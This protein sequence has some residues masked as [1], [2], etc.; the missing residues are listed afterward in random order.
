[1]KTQY[2]KSSIKIRGKVSRGTRCMAAFLIFS[3]T[4]FQQFL[5]AQSVAPIPNIGKSAVI[6]D[7]QRAEINIRSIVPLA[8][9]SQERIP[10]HSSSHSGFASVTTKTDPPIPLK[11]PETVNRLEE[12][13]TEG[14]TGVRT[15]IPSTHYAVT[16]KVQSHLQKIVKPA[17]LP[18]PAPVSI[19]KKLAVLA[20]ALIN[21]DVK[22]LAALKQDEFMDLYLVAIGVDL[23]AW[24]AE[25]EKE[26]FFQNMFKEDKGPWILVF[27]AM[28]PTSMHEYMGDLELASMAGDITGAKKLPV[29]MTVVHRGKDL[30]VE[31]QGAYDLWLTFRINEKDEVVVSKE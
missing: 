21:L 16:Q 5:L 12:A 13:L 4:F 6:G 29:N 27:L 19:P 10:T 15:S 1:M 9:D 23:S 17:T 28:S 11:E 8:S 14:G 2:E 24:M 3:F 25:N 26:T 22:G 7:G 20:E 18:K 31:T 30:V